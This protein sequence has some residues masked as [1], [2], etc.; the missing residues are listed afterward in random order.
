LNRPGKAEVRAWM[1]Q[2]RLAA[3][4]PPGGDEIRRALGWSAVA[5]P[6]LV[7]RAPVKN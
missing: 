6:A 4:A 3:A 1:M 7:R 5:D 2:R